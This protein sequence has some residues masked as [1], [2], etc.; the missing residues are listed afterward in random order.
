MFEN[1]LLLSSKGHYETTASR[2]EAV[3]KRQEEAPADTPREAMR[4]AVKR[5]TVQRVWNERRRMRRQR[6]AS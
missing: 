2:V 5:Q 6:T 3:R 4:Q 1:T